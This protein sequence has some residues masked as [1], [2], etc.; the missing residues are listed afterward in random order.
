MFG[1][2]RQTAVLQL[3]VAPGGPYAT[4]PQP[5]SLGFYGPE[6]LK[7]F[8]DSAGGLSFPYISLTFLV[9]DALMQAPIVQGF[10]DSASSPDPYM[11]IMM[12]TIT[13]K[14]I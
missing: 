13:T 10:R 4:P 2:R 1:V 12:I 3:L 14:E 11:M 8:L 6:N 7:P 9:P 5:R